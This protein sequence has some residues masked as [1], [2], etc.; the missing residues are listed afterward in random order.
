LSDAERDHVCRY[1]GTDGSRV[2]DDLTRLALASV[3]HTAII[4]LQDILDLG[5]EA[6]INTP[7]APEGNWTWRAEAS[8]LT[9]A[10]AN[11]LGEQTTLYGRAYH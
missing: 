1:V 10:R 2:S 4:P 11:W 9:E 8:Q 5:S 3:A 7:G 6:R